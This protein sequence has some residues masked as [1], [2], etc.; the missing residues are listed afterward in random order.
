MIAWILARLAPLLGILLVAAISLAGVQTVRVH[1]KTTELAQLRATNIEVSLAREQ[2]YTS[3]L[4]RARKSE[5]ELADQAVKTR[6]IHDDKIKTVNARLAAALV[7]LRNRPE[8]RLA[9]DG[10]AATDSSTAAGATGSQ[11][12][13]PDARFLIG[14]ASRADRLRS[15]L[16]QCYADY[17]S[18]RARLPK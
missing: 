4:L 3:N 12:S 7:S 6:K 13:G 15:A 11:L 14:E 18:V 8:Q 2:E 17:E 5:Q 16:E 9:S 10:P 1:Q